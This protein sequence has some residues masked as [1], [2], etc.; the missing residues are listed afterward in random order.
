MYPIFF[1]SLDALCARGDQFAVLDDRL[2]LFGDSP[3]DEVA[4]RILK[5]KVWLKVPLNAINLISAR[6]ILFRSYKI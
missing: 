1:S 4:I 2:E 3:L 6:S 5:R